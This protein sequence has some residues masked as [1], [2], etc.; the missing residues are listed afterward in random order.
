MHLFFFY[1]LRNE[2]DGVQDQTVAREMFQLRC[3]QVGHRHQEL[4]TKG[5]G[6]LLRHLL[7]GKVLDSLR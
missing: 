1:T 2:K 3:V 4:Y 5:T 6:S 7:R